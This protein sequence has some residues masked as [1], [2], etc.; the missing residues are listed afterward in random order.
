[1]TPWL[2]SHQGFD[3]VL[4]RWRVLSAYLRPNPVEDS[5]YISRRDRTIS[6]ALQAFSR[7]FA[8]WQNPKYRD[9]DRVRSLTEIM[10]S[11]ADLG[12]WLFSQPS[13]FKFHWGT[14]ENI[15]AHTIVVAPALLKV[16]DE[17]AQSLS[18][19]QVMIE[20]VIRRL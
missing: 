9:E 8:P 5:T 3:E 11:A 19:A 13:T 15:E 10:K 17:S 6:E 2:T 4:A 7:A 14:P 16:A 20:M 18:K 1:M 12:I